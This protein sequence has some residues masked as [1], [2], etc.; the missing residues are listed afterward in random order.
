MGWKKRVGVGV[1]CNL[2]ENSKKEEPLL[3]TVNN[4]DLKKNIKRK[5]KGKGERRGQKER[6]KQNEKRWGGG[7]ARA[8][9]AS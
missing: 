4:S 8:M 2:Q 7:G 1:A 6:K 9:R 3:T 5:E